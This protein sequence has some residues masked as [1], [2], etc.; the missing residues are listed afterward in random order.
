MERW[1]WTLFQCLYYWLTLG[2]FFLILTRGVKM[3]KYEELALHQTQVLCLFSYLVFQRLGSKNL[4]AA[5][6]IPSTL[7]ETGLF[8]SQKDFARKTSP[9]RL[10]YSLLKI[11]I[12]VRKQSDW[13]SRNK[14]YM[15]F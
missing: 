11:R 8:F 15:A 5:T 12:K 7:A 14:G 1:P 3:T 9:I 10:S 6:E 4:V 13:S 2:R